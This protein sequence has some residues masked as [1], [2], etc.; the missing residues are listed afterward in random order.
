MEC[1]G[2]ALGKTS[3]VFAVVALGP[4]E[5]RELTARGV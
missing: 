5:K 4:F 3:P 1:W 2:D